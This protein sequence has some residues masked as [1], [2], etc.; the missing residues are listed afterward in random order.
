L[1][2]PKEFSRKICLSCLKAKGVDTYIR[3]IQKPGEARRTKGPNP[4]CHMVNSHG[5]LSHDMTLL[6]KTLKTDRISHM[7]KFGF[8]DVRFE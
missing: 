5:E 4:K 7:K 6:V 8:Q 1:L 2:F 3:K